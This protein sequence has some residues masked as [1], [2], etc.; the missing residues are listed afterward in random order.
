MELVQFDEAKFRERTQQVNSYLQKMLPIYLNRY[1]N[2]VFIKVE[3]AE[4]IVAIYSDIIYPK[5]KIIVPDKINVYK[6]AASHEQA[7]V[8][9]QPFSSESLNAIENRRMNAEFA[10]NVAFTNIECFWRVCE[11]NPDH[12]EIGAEMEEVSWK[13]AQDKNHPRTINH[14]DCDAALE[15]GKA[16]HIE[17]LI[18]KDLDE[19]HVHTV[20]SFLRMY[21]VFQQQTYSF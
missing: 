5:F 16:E 2:D 9:V 14:V 15:I 10:F 20:A 1:A 18:S 21:Y 11:G 19:Y 3:S 8:Q 7:I 13:L 17:W 12:K 6:I 4:R